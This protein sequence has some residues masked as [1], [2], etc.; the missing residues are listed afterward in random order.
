MNEGVCAREGKHGI[1]KDACGRAGQTA[2]QGVLRDETAASEIVDIEAES[3]TQI[4]WIG[5]SL[6]FEIIQRGW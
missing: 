4:W 1:T 2:R 3:G 5:W 6:R